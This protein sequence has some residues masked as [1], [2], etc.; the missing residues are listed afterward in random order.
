MCEDVDSNHST[1]KN[2]E[3]CNTEQGHAGLESAVEPVWWESVLNL[4]N[5]CS[6]ALKTVL[7]IKMCDIH[8]FWQIYLNLAM[9]GKDSTTLNIELAVDESLTPFPMSLCGSQ[10]FHSGWMEIVCRVKFPGFFVCLFVLGFL[11][12][13]L[14]VSHHGLH[15]HIDNGP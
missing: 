5:A 10:P 8:W 6:S 3:W 9:P 2:G 12:T 11:S 13:L 4:W 14:E 7:R 15:F 1:T